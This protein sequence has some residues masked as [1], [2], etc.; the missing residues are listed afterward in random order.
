MLGKV[1]DS[2]AAD[3]RSAGNSSA[4]DDGLLGLLDGFG[5]QD[6]NS[7]GG[8]SA[9]V[10]LEAV[11]RDILGLIQQALG[12]QSSSGRNSRRV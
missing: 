11:G 5:A 10:S 4:G 1:L 6:V 9:L 7:L 8:D 12:S 2:A 3:A